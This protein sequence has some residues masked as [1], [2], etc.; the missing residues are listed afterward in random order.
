MGQE[1][2]SLELAHLLHQLRRRE[3][4]RRGGQELT[5]RELSA[6]T[7]WSLG[8]VAQYFSGKSVPPVDRF[9]VLVRLLGATAA[10]LGAL[11]TARDAAADGRRKGPAAA[12]GGQSFRL[13]GPVVVAGPAGAARLTGPK[14]RALVA[15]LALHAGSVL[16]QAKLIDALWGDDPP[17]TAVETLYSYVARI[18]HAFDGCGLAGV[19]HT[20]SSG[21]LLAVRRDAV[22]AARLEERVAQARAA[23]AAGKAREAVTCLSEGLSLWRGD[24]LADAPVHGWGAA[25]VA[26]LGELCWTAREDLWEARLA[27]GEHADAAG[28][29]GKLLVG[30]PGRER[31]VESYM[32]ALHRCG[33]SN[34][35][36][37]A[38]QRLR[39]YLAE[40][41][42]AEPGA[43][44]QRVHVAIVRRDPGL[45]VAPT[46]G[47][48]PGR[49]WHRPPP[50]QLPPRIGHFTGRDGELAVLDG[51][52]GAAAEVGVV[53]GPAG[54]GKTALAVQ[55]AHR[56]ADRCPDGQLYVDLRGHDPAAALPVAEALAQ[57][58]AGLGVPAAEIPA[59]LTARLGLYRSAV[60]R[61]RVLVLLDDAADADQVSSLVPPAPSL[62]LVTS[63]NRLT[64]LAV[65][66]AVSAVHLD[67]LHPGDALALLRRVLGA[68]RVAA[69]PAAARRLTEL[70][71]GMPLALRIAAAKL[72]AGPH[73]LID[74]FNAELAD[75]RLDAL[76]V[77]GDSRSIRAVFA[78]AYRAL[79]PAAARLFGRLGRHPGPT[80]AV[81]LAVALAEAPPG[82]GRAALDE[83]AAAHL[84][85]EVARGRYRF[86]DLIRAYAFEVA[87]PV[88][89]ARA[90]TRIFEWYL[91]VG[92]A[93]NR[94]FSPARNR[95]GMISAQPPIEVPFPA[96]HAAAL[97]FVD[98]EYASVPAVLD[99]AARRGA[100][101]DTWR[102]AYLF[103]GFFTLRGHNGARV[104]AARLGL[105]A[106]R[107]LADPDAE[108]VLRSLLGLA[109][110]AVG[111][112]EQALAH[113]GT[114]LT[115]V[116]AAGDLAG[117]A[118][119]LNNIG[120]ARTALGLLASAMEAFTQALALR[121]ADADHA[122]V[123]T[124]LN[125]I[126]HLHI[127]LGEPA[128]A[129]EHLLRALAL[130]RRLGLPRHEACYLM[131]LGQAHRADRDPDAALEHLSAALAIRRELGERRLEADT[132]NE[133]GLASRDRGDRV[134]ASA[135]FRGALALARELADPHLEATTR[136]YLTGQEPPMVTVA[137]ASTTAPADTAEIRT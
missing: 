31:L 20:K 10:E 41:V 2:A 39:A 58:L 133:L 65:D 105:A 9:D 23:V 89:A 27:L 107:R 38:Y 121:S 54:I 32:L 98:G 26:R 74:A 24:A 126:G 94:V 70:C 87:E 113:F 30:A 6:R 56:A 11:A 14:P 93:A 84:V 44:L 7:G 47:P 80:F 106:A 101:R 63:R 116:T 60:H 114:A 100:D 99:L 43:R 61:R 132:L 62:L 124:L 131:S 68:D 136:S 36:V 81:S 109:C 8:I 49:G 50:A 73:G 128:L 91:A 112:H 88:E 5:Y 28:E 118:M 137:T 46:A 53:C 4:R 40:Q 90:E 97:A 104:D 119:V 42:G 34:E 15:L 75:G 33:R 96:D 21:Y 135:H 71:G 103:T 16:S 127:Q 123:A 122:D 37:E 85:V 25:E 45:D 17:R 102:L 18:R 120:H 72:A 59:E 55:W 66:H 48:G 76:S 108:A 77:P 110:H 51:L 115:L 57:L 12:A 3:A 67:V 79:S 78:S 19:L 64:G 83:L 1:Q 92:D 82:G 29:L 95:A 111:D 22:D 129:R 134:A 125:N 35:A 69:E 86:H 130:A 52:H 117:Q 13:L